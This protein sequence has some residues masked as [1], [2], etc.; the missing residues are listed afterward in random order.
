MYVCVNIRNS[1]A[2]YSVSSK[3]FRLQGYI[4]L[5]RKT[6]KKVWVCRP[7][8]TSG[9]ELRPG[10]CA[11]QLGHDKLEY[12]IPLILFLLIPYIQK[13]YTLELQQQKYQDL[14]Y[15]RLT[16]GDE[17]HVIPYLVLKNSSALNYHFWK[18]RM[19]YE[20]HVMMLHGRK[21][22]CSFCP[23]PEL[24]GQQLPHNTFSFFDTCISLM[25]WQLMKIMQNQG[26]SR[27]LRHH[28][29]LEV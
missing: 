18:Q 14:Q 27:S 2:S 28:L 29:P 22:H 23:I 6:K 5:F 1:F 8:Q 21:L 10:Y 15:A 25:Q 3:F 16:Y 26:Y 13:Q 7:S 17:C 4:L 24:S 12:L 11:L 19:V 9:P 20:S